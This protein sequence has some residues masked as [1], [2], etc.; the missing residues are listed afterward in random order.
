MHAL[1]MQ[2]PIWNI[3]TRYHPQENFREKKKNENNKNGFII[4]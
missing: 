1:V 4:I 2:P 3:K